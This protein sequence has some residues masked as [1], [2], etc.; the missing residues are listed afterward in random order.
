MT[1][2]TFMENPFKY[3]HAL[4]VGS[5]SKDKMIVIFNSILSFKKKLIFMEISTV[6]NL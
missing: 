2:I 6:L 3:C 5:A 4:P 1:E